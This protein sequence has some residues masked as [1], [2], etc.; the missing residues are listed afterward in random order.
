MDWTK[1]GRRKKVGQKKL[2]E[3]WAHDS[4][5]MSTFKKIAGHLYI[6]PQLSKNGQ[7][8]ISDFNYKY[9]SH[10]IS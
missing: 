1:T 10:Q 2:D 9:L 5:H 3:N 8:I 6:W 7:I 4:S